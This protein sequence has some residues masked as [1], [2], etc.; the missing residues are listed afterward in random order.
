MSAMRRLW[1]EF[2]GFAMSG[3]MLDLALGF[4]I[5]T[6]FATL[7][8]SLANNVLMQFVAAIFGKQDFTKL[9]VN[10]NGADILYGSFLTD[11]LN[12]LML[13]GVLFLIV[14]LIMFAG[15][16][17]RAFGDKQC[18]YCQE[19]VAPTAMV[20]KWCRQQ[21]VAELPSLVEAQRLLDEQTAR[22]RVPVPLPPL[23]IPGRRRTDPEAVGDRTD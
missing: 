13:A 3:N 14:K 11:L 16:Q 12:F 21:L 8:Q 22:R 19:R 7:I 5:G 18:P 4:L 1:Q 20:C 2:K 6:A 23:P 10:V 9:A 17:R 15:G